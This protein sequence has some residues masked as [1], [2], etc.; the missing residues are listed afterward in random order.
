MKPYY[1][2]DCPTCKQPKYSKAKRPP[3]GKILEHMRNS[4]CYTCSKLGTN[5]PRFGVTWQGDSLKKLS[6]SMLGKNTWS[7]GKKLTQTH[8]DNITSGLRKAYDSKTRLADG[9]TISLGMENGLA[10]GKSRD[11]YEKIISDKK[12]YYNEVHKITKRQDIQSLKHFE[13][14]GKAK[15]GTDNYQLDHI[16]PISEGFRNNIDPEIIGDISN[17][18]FIPWKENIL[19]NK[20]NKLI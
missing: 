19:R 10:I 8:K 18:R 6:N 3:A 5:N 7:R 20:K 13:K 14:R 2:C 12:K 4:N 17:L 1:V 15:L 9:Y 11:E 16:I